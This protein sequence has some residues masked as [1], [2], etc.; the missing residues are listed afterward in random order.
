MNEDVSPI[1]NGDLLLLLLKE[2]IR[3]PPVE[4]GSLSNYLQGFIHSMWL[5]WDFFH[6]QLSFAISDQLAT[7]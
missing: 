7:L 3:H 1:K 6:Q 4:V 5:P 2:E